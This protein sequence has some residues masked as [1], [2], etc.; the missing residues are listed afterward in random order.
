M[1]LERFFK[2][3]AKSLDDSTS[4]ERRQARLPIVGRGPAVGVS[5]TSISYFRGI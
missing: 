4:G 5:V 3:E 1:C 2:V